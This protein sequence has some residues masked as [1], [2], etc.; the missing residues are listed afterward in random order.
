MYYYDI[1]IIGGL[2]KQQV[3]LI[4]MQKSVYQKAEVAKQLYLEQRDKHKLPKWSSEPK[5]IEAT[6]YWLCEYPKGI[7]KQAK[8]ELK[9]VRKALYNPLGNAVKE[10][11]SEVTLG[12]TVFCLAALVIFLFLM[13]CIWYIS[14]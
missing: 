11:K 10:V 9:E 13:G 7:S 6:S 1:D 8:K 12:A 4:L 3:Q 5:I 14:T 2:T